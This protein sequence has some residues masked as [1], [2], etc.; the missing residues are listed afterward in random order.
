M[1]RD[2]TCLL[3]GGGNLVEVRKAIALRGCRIVMINFQEAIDR[4]APSDEIV[5]AEGVDFT[6]PLGVVRRLLE[7][8]KVW[9]F[10]AVVP[11][12]E[13]GIQPCALVASQLGLPTLALKAVQ[14]TRDKL[15][16]RRTLEQAGL[17]QLRYASCTTFE[18]AEAFFKFG[19][20]AP[21]IVK[22]NGGTGSDGVSKVTSSE[23]VAEAFGLAT[24]ARAYHG[25]VLCEEFI[26][27]PE[28]SVEGFSLHGGFVPV[29]ITDKITDARFLEIGHNQP[30]AHP[31]ELQQ[32]AFA[33]TAQAL[34]AL[35]VTHGV[36]HTELKLT[37]GGP[38]MIETHTRNGGDSI[39][40][41][42]ERTTGVDLADVVVGISFGEEP[43][44]RPRRTGL[45]AAIRF[46]PGGRQG[47]V[48]A[49]EMPATKSCALIESA[50]VYLQVGDLAIGRSSSL[51]RLGEVIA[52]GPTPEAVGLA[53]DSFLAN[54]KVSL[55]EDSP[56]TAQA[57]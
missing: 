44:V 53:A 56:W 4:M 41:L 9:N 49:I 19:G 30:S 34:A 17:G 7:L 35:G 15:R 18:Q 6:H 47:R 8:N 21:I 38:V 39:H 23:K 50:S 22:P 55:Q 40:L 16:M 42:T 33:F 36:S 52:V 13:Y 27:G 31:A 14:N 48:R 11:I 45:A 3:V 37:P 54:M 46:L 28:V 43:Q 1:K 20:G 24:S 12:S 25:G 5:H 57:V 29:A 2:P 32:R 26:E 10:R 51:D